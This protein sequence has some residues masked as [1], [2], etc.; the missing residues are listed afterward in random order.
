MTKPDAEKWRAD[1]LREEYLYYGFQYYAVARCAV[2][3]R[4]NPVAGNLCHHAIEMLLKGGLCRHT[5]E[6]M[7][8]RMG[9]RLPRIWQEFRVHFDPTG[10][11]ACFDALVQDLQGYEDIRYPEQTA[12]QGLSSSLQFGNAPP[13][14]VSGNADGMP[15]Y[16]LSVGAVDALVKAICDA[17]SIN[18]KFF[19]TGFQ[20]P[21]STYLRHEN[22]EDLF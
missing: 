2:A 10:K 9:H 17:C 18:P 14:E 21:G 15:T 3:A 19:T 11:L 8:I 12:Q 5:T 7:R 4:A 20:P 1:R 16:H 6:D 22:A 13:P